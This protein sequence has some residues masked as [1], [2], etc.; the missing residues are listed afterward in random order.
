RHFHRANLDG[1]QVEV[2]GGRVRPTGMVFVTGDVDAAC[3]PV[4]PCPP[5]TNCSAVEKIY[6]AT[7]NDP[8]FEGR[9][10]RADADG[11]G[12]E[13]IVPGLLPSACC[14]NPI[15]IAVDGTVGKL[16]WSMGWVT[17]GVAT[18]NAGRANLDGTDVELLL[19]LPAVS[20]SEVSE[21]ALDP[22][23]GKVYFHRDEFPAGSD[24]IYRT[25]LDGSNL[26]TFL[27]SPGVGGMQ[28]DAANGKIYMQ[29]SLDK[30]VVA[31]VNELNPPLTTVI[32]STTLIGFA[33][34]D[35][36]WGKLYYFEELS[37]PDKRSMRANIDGT[38]IE[39][40]GTHPGNLAEQPR[41]A[42]DPVSGRMYEPR[43]GGPNSVLIR[44][45]IA[46]ESDPFCV[47]CGA[48][49]RI[50]HAAL[51]MSKAPPIPGDLNG[52]GVVNVLDLL[53]VIS[54]WGPCPPPPGSCAADISP[55]GG[56]GTVNILDLLAVI[57]NWG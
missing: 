21:V 40:L 29:K 53:A 7:S 4:D 48:E 13:V 23:V 50:A 16:Y 12:A 42:L 44:A 54:A 10:W 31:S 27:T 34:L 15:S 22:L 5:K 28:I 9:V 57:S 3:G 56:D 24:T 8:P 32:D 37:G 14:L 2:I 51:L 39:V 20:G 38:N 46:D 25:N 47:V 36:D 6:W 45:D 19:D 18:W 52:D 41:I 55:P 30:I 35:P 1:S 26:E 11:S 49:G 43:D 33:G 17:Q